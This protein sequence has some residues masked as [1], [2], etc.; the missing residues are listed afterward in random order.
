MFRI[1]VLVKLASQL[2]RVFSPAASV[3]NSDCIPDDI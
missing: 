2:G 3:N 1:F